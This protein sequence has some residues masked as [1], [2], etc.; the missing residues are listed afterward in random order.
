MFD[1][2]SFAVNVL[3]KKEGD[4]W[5]AHCLEL[6]IVA[7]ANTAEEARQDMIDLVVEQIKYA[8]S[9]DNMENLFFPAP[10]EVWEEFF[11]CKAKSAEDYQLKNGPEAKGLRG[12]LANTCFAS[13]HCNTSE[14]CH[15]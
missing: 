7:S 12:I 13:E 10:K 4:S 11:A 15:A 6:D 1:N 5:T 2:D 8:L 3:V 14:L 9:N